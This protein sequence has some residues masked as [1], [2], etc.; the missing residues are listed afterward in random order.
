MGAI[1]THSAA[2]LEIREFRISEKVAHNQ[3]TDQI[4]LEQQDWFD[5]GLIVF[6]AA[7]SLSIPQ[8]GKIS[9]SDTKK[10]SYV[11][12]GYD[13]KGVPQKIGKKEIGVSIRGELKKLGDKSGVYQGYFLFLQYK[14]ITIRGNTVTRRSDGL[15]FY[16]PIFYQFEIETEVTLA[17]GA[18]LFLGGLQEKENK[19]PTRIL[20]IKLTE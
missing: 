19:E 4:S 7:N 17:P 3:V 6:D 12:E 13:K 15:G 9:Y 16:S 14:N 18:W 10:V 1:A 5:K 20:A 8:D 2:T 11:S